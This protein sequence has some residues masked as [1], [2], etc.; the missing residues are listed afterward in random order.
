MVEAAPTRL[1]TPRP[2]STAGP[3]KSRITSV[4]ASR[5]L[6]TAADRKPSLVLAS[7]TDERSRAKVEAMFLSG[8][9]TL[10]LDD[11]VRVH[12]AVRAENRHGSD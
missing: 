3:A 12:R 5:H 4:A 2:W 7:K 10:R 9:K 6:G 1:A 8:C 11:A